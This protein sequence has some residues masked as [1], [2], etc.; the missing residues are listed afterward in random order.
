[1]CVWKYYSY[2]GAIFDSDGI[3]QEVAVKGKKLFML[4]A[5]ETMQ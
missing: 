5:W 2:K 1:M 3:E 4:D